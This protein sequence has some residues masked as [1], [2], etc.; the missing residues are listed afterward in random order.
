MIRIW[1]MLDKKKL[2]IIFSIMVFEAVS[3]LFLP[4][5]AAKILNVAART[6]SQSGIWQYGSWML[7]ASLMTIVL[8]FIS[9]RMCAKESQGLGNHLRKQIFS[10]VMAFS[11]DDLSRFETST[12]I[13]RTTNDVMQIQIITMMT[14]RMI[15][16]TP[17]IVAVSAYFAYQTQSELAWIYWITLPLICVLVFVIMRIVTPIYR[18]VQSIMDRLNKVFREGLTGVR[19]IRAFNTSTYEEARFDEVNQDY[20]DTNV[21]GFSIMSLLLPSLLLVVGVSNVLIFTQGVK[22]IEVGIME[23]GNIIAYIQYSNQILMSILMVG[24]LFIFI[25]RAQVSADRILEVLDT[26]A[27]IQSVKDPRPIPQD[28]P[29]QLSF[30]GVDFG[31][32]QAQRPAVSKLNFTVNQGETLAIIGGTGSGKTTIANLIPRLYEASAGAVRLNGVDVRLLDQEALR[33]C[34][35]YATQKAMLF[36]GTIRS[37]L[38]YGKSNATDEQLWRALDIAQADFVRDL[39]EGLDAR[40]EQAGN[41]FSGGQKQRLSIARAIVSQPAIYLF[42]DSFSALDFKTD[43]KLRQALKENIQD[44]IIIIIAQRVSTVMDADQ[45]LVLDNGQ[46]V[47]RGSHQSLLDSNPVYQEIV[48]SQI[49]EEG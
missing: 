44:A 17:I 10:Q 27:S 6:G 16:M 20:R 3:L 47:G 49:K 42:D 2:A 18:R 11:Q 30:Q 14:L 46:I 40:V 32:P 13:T 21:K 37:N 36:A 19:V 29:W 48:R 31:F 7:V 34:I 38:L 43:A 45:I 4:T 23:V 28:G 8:A 15:V 33:A 26:K 25:P 41:N 5:I 1:G 39:P 35:G 12:L 9:V 22:L 24:M